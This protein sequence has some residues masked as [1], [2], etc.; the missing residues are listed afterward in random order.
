M[1]RESFKNILNILQICLLLYLFLTSIELMGIGLKNLGID[2]KTLMHQATG[3]PFMALF[4]GILV[5]GIIQ[6]SSTTTSL[7]VSMVGAGFLDIIHAV[8]IIMGANIGTS[9]TNLLVSFGHIRNRNEFQKAFGASVVHDIFNVLTVLLLFP[10]QISTNFLGNTALFMGRTFE[11]MGGIKLLNPIKLA[12]D[13]FTNVLTLLFQK[14][15]ILILIVSL[16]L[17]FFALGYIVK[18]IKSLVLRKIESFFSKYIFTT[19]FRSF[20]FGLI[21]TSIIQSSS[22]TTSLVVPLAGAGILNLNQIFPYTVGANIGTTITAFLAS[23][24]T[25]NVNGISIA[26]AHTIFNVLGTIIWLPLRKVPIFLA[27][28][29]AVLAAKYRVVPFIFIVL[30]FY[31]IPIILI[32]VF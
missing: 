14:N 12:V 18:I 6:S 21:L 28:K 7:V 3:N 9:V 4:I 16:A 20:L 8:P 24:A 13:P 26:F 19:T 27:Q 10:L 1:K 17:L 2:V 29:F 15:G 25:G 32:Y 5:T 31:A 11:E 23:L 22:V 30:I